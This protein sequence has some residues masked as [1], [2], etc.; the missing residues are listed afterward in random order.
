MFCVPSPKVDKTYC[1]L[2]Y[3]V[4][5]FRVDQTDFGLTVRYVPSPRVDQNRHVLFC[6]FLFGF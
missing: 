1:I 6:S 3:T 2:L 5:L 4:R